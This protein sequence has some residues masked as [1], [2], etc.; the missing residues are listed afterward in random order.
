MSPCHSRDNSD[1]EDTERPSKRLATEDAVALTA[2]LKCEAPEVEDE[3]MDCPGAFECPICLELMV[4][5]TVGE[6]TPLEYDSICGQK[7]SC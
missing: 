2:N 5:P 1:D 4:E 6:Y 7:Y 3:L